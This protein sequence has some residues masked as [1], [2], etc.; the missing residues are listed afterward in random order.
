MMLEKA[1]PLRLSSGRVS[2]WPRLL[3]TLD[4]LSGL[5]IELLVL[6]YTVRTLRLENTKHILLLRFTGPVD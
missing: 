4:P 1:P 5:L 2:L 3:R 6:Y